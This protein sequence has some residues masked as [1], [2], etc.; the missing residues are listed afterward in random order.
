MDSLNQKPLKSKEYQNP[1]LKKDTT[2]FF[3]IHTHFQQHYE[4]SF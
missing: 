4:Y 1:L 2:H 3:L